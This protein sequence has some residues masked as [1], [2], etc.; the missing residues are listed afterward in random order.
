MATRPQRAL[1]V[2]GRRRN[3]QPQ[4]YFN[5]RTVPFSVQ[6]FFI[7]PVLPGET[8]KN[9]LLQA[10]VVSNPIKNPLIGW[11]NEYY[12][13]YVKHR[14]LDIR[15]TLTEMML[16]PELDTSPHNEAAAPAYYHAGGTINWSKQCLKRVVEEYFRNEGEAWDA[17]L[18]NG[19]PAAAHNGESFLQSMM[20]DS[21]Y[22]A[23]QAPDVDLDGDG[24]ITAQEISRAMQMWEFQRA[25]NLTDMDYEDFLATYGVRQPRV[26]LHK[27]ELVRYLRNWTY[28]S[29]TVDPATGTPSSALSWSIAER[30]DKDR[31][32]NEP[33][34]LFGVTVTRPK[35]Y[36]RP[37]VGSAV[38]MMTDAVSW[39][40]A[41]MMDDPTTSLKHFAEGSGPVPSIADDGGYWI[42]IRDLFMYG[43]QFLNYSP[44]GVDN[45]NLVALPDATGQR[46]YPTQADVDALFSTAAANKINADGIVTLTIAS[47]IRDTS[48][49]T[50]AVA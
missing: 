34:F 50:P 25:N 29:N 17:N 8:M 21:D 11:W 22:L 26:E 49:G 12:I 19:L 30:A 36:L 35:V 5:L 24:T 48:P 46:R 20:N 16:D 1:G 9:F 18:I 10:R 15:D 7:A 41:I 14:D 42:D 31:F 37:Q 40:P 33:G 6:P 23:D 38:E 44:T 27:P 3:R 32:F 47:F 28:P 13:F 45:A 4:H 39:L 2:T 43:D